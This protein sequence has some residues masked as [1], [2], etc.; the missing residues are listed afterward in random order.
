MPDQQDAP[1][2]RLLADSARAVWPDYRDAAPRHVLEPVAYHRLLAPLGT[3]A[4][5]Q[6]DH[7]QRLAPQLSGHP[8]AAFTQS[9]AMRPHLDVLPE[10]VH[11]A[12]RAAYDEA[13][14]A[15]YPPEPDGGVLF[16]FRRTFVVLTKDP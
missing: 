9:T 6:T 1:S 5:W 12:F 11:A 7:L 3:V 2:H 10:H 4:V 14:A 16:P 8:V 15:A 13:L